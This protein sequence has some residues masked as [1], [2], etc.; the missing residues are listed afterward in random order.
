MRI[1]FHE[2]INDCLDR[3]LLFPLDLKL[4]NVTPVYKKQSKHSTDNYRPV[5][6]LSNTFKI[7]ER[8]I[9]DQIHSYFDKILPN[10]QCEFHKDYNAQHGLIALIE[11]WKKGV[12]NDGAFGA[13]LTDLLKV[14]DCLSREF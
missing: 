13:L 2:S 5:S 3:S 4:A 8:C 11:K 7:Y 6:T 12:D 14:F 10:R 9:C 1:Y